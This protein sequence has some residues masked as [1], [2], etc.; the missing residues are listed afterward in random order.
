MDGQDEEQPSL[1]RR[2]YAYRIV[3]VQE[4]KHDPSLNVHMAI[5][6][7]SAFL[8]HQV[9]CMMAILFMIGK[10]KEPVDI[11]P[12]LLDVEK[13]KERPNYRIAPGDN[14]ILSECGFEGLN[15]QN[16][17][18]Y[19][20]FENYTTIKAQYQ[21]ATIDQS[22][23]SVL[24][25]YYFDQLVK[26]SSI[27]SDCRGIISIDPNNKYNIDENEPTK[28]HSWLEVVNSIKVTKRS[29]KKK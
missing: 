14:L 16:A 4:N 29:D 7:G 22:L 12:T 24:L 26:T 5:I 2:I 6:K 11:I 28:N 19:A 9:R 3:C 13:V 20:D 21:S 23:L 18:F 17:N 27:T 25:K 15:W 8:W 10:K 1:K